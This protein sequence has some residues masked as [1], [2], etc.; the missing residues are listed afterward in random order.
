MLSLELSPSQTGPAQAMVG[1]GA[2]ALSGC[3]V[4]GCLLC[5]EL[6]RAAR[7]GCKTD[8]MDISHRAVCHSVGMC[9]GG[10]ILCL[11]SLAN[12]CGRCDTDGAFMFS[13]KT[14]AAA[15]RKQRGGAREVDVMQTG[16]QG[17]SGSAV[18]R[19]R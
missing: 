6:A 4:I 10:T 14:L 12:G 1:D 8:R 16:T 11:S 19:F 17:T 2:R 3:E 15:L 7:R 5:S 13:G 18:R 9:A